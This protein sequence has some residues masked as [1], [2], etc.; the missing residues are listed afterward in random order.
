MLPIEEGQWQVTLLGAHGGEPDA[1]QKRQEDFAA[2]ARSARHPLV[3]D[4]I[5]DAEPL[6]PVHLVRHMRWRRRRCTGLAGRWPDGFALP[7][8]G[9]LEGDATAGEQAA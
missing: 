7:C 9:A 6:G 5:A 2:F 4:L 1:R 3:A 8:L